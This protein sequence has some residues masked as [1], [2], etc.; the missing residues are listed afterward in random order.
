MKKVLLLVESSTAYGRKIS[1][2]VSQYVREHGRWT[3]HIEDRGLF[4]IP[5]PLKN[6]WNGDGIIAR[7]SGKAI[8]R[9]LSR[10]RCPIVELLGDV[11]GENSVD[12]TADTLGGIELCIDHYLKKR[13]PSIG[14]YAFGWNWWIEKRKKLF[15][16][17]TL[18]KGID[19]HC[20]VDSSS[21]KSDPQPQWDDKYEPPLKKW[22]RRLPF[23]TGIIAA[24]DYQAMRLLNVCQRSGIKV[25]EQIAILG[26]DNDE[27]LCNL[28][29]PPLSSLDQDAE[30]VGYQAAELLDLKMNRRK[31]PLTPIIIP[32]KGIV[33]RRSSELTAIDDEDVAAA[34]H[35]IAE[36]AVHGIGID[37]VIRHVGLSKSTLL[38]RFQKE[39]HRSPKEEIIRVR[40]DHAKNLLANSGLTVHAVALRC[41]FA[42][43][44]YFTTA[45]KSYTGQTP[46]CY[47]QEH[48]KPS[49]VK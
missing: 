18:Q 17:I 6:G 28:V 26:V 15:L 27:H 5:T 13:I 40:F 38:R 43:V 8:Q 9:A 16:E 2:G 14:F 33:S 35:Y 30:M 37:D 12:V 47:R 21:Q 49:D 32:P 45:F 44:E 4:C 20:F 22:I 24:N 23:R 42:S 31:L 39:L 10:C 25:P 1:D 29:T 46:A 19:A 7:T 48:R 11:N 41:G 36:E 34:L 3:L